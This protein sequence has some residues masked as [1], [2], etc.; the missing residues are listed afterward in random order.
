MDA[1]KNKQGFPHLREPVWVKKLIHESIILFGTWNIDTLIGI[2]ME[3]VDI[4]TR[5]KIDVP[6]IN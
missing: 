5:R 6:T 4:M 2:Y 3:L 1:L